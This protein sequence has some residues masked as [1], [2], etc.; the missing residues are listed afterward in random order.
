ME[1]T[2]TNPIMLNELVHTSAGTI[3][4]T[5]S[6]NRQSKKFFYLKAAYG[7]QF[8]NA[9]ETASHVSYAVETAF[10]VSYAVVMDLIYQS[11]VLIKS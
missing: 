4:N 2:F 7:L 9:V 6:S 5:Y 1:D 8:S 11:R 10:H 3:H